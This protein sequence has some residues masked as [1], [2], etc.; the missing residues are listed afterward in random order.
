MTSEHKTPVGEKAFAALLEKIEAVKKERPLDLS[1]G[2]DLAVGIMNLIALEEHLFFTGAKTADPS[3]HDLTQEV[4]EMRKHLMEELL[5]KAQYEGETWCA[6]KHLLSACMRLIEVG[7]KYRTEGDREASDRTLKNAY[8]LYT[9]FSALKL[10]L[11]DAKGL[12]AAAESAKKEEGMTQ[13]ELI[14][15]L[16]SCCDE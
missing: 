9:M 3:Y 4:R 14:A 16:A 12:K 11:I 13:E 7:G 1:R 8:R 15:K 6:T 2:E 5:P 10:K